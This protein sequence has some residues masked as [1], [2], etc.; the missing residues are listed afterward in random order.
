MLTA[1]TEAT[2]AAIVWVLY[3]DEIVDGVVDRLV[4]TEEDD[5]RHNAADTVEEHFLQSLSGQLLHSIGGEFCPGL[6]IVH[7]RS[8]VTA[9]E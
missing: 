2:T 4:L 6:S 9:R 7:P 8:E 1:Y 3:V 5:P